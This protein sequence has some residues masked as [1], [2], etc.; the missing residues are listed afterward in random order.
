MER[1]SGY[2]RVGISGRHRLGTGFDQKITHLK[3]L[4]PIGHGPGGPG[5]VGAVAA[6]FVQKVAAAPAVPDGTLQGGLGLGVVALED[7]RVDGDGGGCRRLL[8][9]GA[10]GDKVGHCAGTGQSV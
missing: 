3:S 8:S 7:C 1:L 2:F 10:E 6:V 9:L 4:E 5:P